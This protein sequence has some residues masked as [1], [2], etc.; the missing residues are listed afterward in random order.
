MIEPHVR[1]L[2]DKHAPAEHKAE[3]HKPDRVVGVCH[4]R[5]NGDGNAALHRQPY[6]K[7]RCECGETVDLPFVERA[8]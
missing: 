3:G 8:K 4:G 5:V 2:W 7:V 6:Q 1:E